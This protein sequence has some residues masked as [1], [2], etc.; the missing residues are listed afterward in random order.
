MCAGASLRP[1][2]SL[3]TKILTLQLAVVLAGVVAGA[4]GSLWVARQQLDSQYEQRALAIAEA[5]AAIPDVREALEPGGGGV[6]IQSIAEGIRKS[7]GASYVVVTDRGGVRYSHPNPA[8]IGRPVD[9]D[10]SVVLAGHTYVG[11]Q[12]GTLGI[13]ARGKA[14]I[15]A[16]GE[17]IGMVSVGYPEERV[18]AQ[19][20]GELPS[21]AITVLVGFGLG[22]AGSIL[23]GRHL[24]RQTFGLEPWE[25]AGLLEEREASLQG[26]REGTIATDR[27]GRITLANAEAQR[28]LGLDRDPVGL[29]PAQIGSP[30]RMR[31]LLAGGLS[32]SDQIVLAGPRMLVASRMPVVVRGEEIG[33]VITLRD[34]TELEG[35]AG[36]VPGVGQLTEAL[37]AQAHEFSN[38]LH[39]IAGLLELGRI[40]E[41][42]RLIAESSGQHQDLAESLLDRIG[43]PVLSAL[44]LSKVAVAGERAIELQ[45]DDDVLAVRGALPLGPQ[46]LITVV[47]NLIDNALDAA[48]A[49]HSDRRWVHVSIREDDAELLIRVHDSGPGV[50]AAHLEQVFREG[51]STKARPSGRRRGLGLALVREVV[52]RHGG[53]VSVRNQG[54]AL[55][56]VRLPI[57]VAAS[58]R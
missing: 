47:G 36:D 51:F 58:R 43:D 42:L 4:L 37:R 7:S 17:V 44:L 13:S 6:S 38:R 39:T 12:K 1:P 56:T 53:E 3:A 25:I 50:D 19:L 57:A 48:S 2:F 31:D 55:F 41:A 34:R 52:R 27:A 18:G 15:W 49:G 29:K 24:K 22:L 54:G 10:P 35:L 14:P 46:E 5:T 23:L 45:L 21:I 9:E 20:L 28:L 40:E 11:V 16:D 33:H 26:I 32:G 30:G 8:L